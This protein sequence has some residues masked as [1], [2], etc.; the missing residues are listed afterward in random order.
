MWLPIT[1]SGE[2]SHIATA[3][4]EQSATVHGITGNIQQVTTIIN[5]SASGTQ[6]FASAASG[7]H[8]MAVELKRIVSGFVIEEPAA[9]PELARNDC[10]GKAYLSQMALSHA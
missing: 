3:A 6:Q 8:L 9:A 2:V 7:L 5:Q 1:I 4:E 10:Q